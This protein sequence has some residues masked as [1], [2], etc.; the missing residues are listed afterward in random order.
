M[1]N[2]RDL[3]ARKRDEEHTKRFEHLELAIANLYT[4]KS[5]AETSSVTEQPQIQPFHVRNV[6]LD[7]PRFDVL[8]QVVE[9]TWFV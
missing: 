4:Q 8:A 3:E 6:K 2:T 5:H 9:S 7:F 1:M